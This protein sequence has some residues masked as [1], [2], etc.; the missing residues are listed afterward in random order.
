MDM[1]RPVK[2]DAAA[3][4]RRQYDN[5]RRQAQTSR[6]R[7]R[8]IEAARKL[9]LEH[10]YAATPIEAAAVAADVG[11]AT[12]YRQFGSKRELLKAIIDVS[13]GGDD[14]PIPFHERPPVVAML[15][16]P[17]PA[18]LLQRFARLVVETS[19]RLDPLY[20]VVEAAAAVDADSADLLALMR[21]QRFVGHGRV[22][23]AL[24]DRAALRK[25]MIVSQAHD[26]IFA[27]CSPELRRVLMAQRGWTTRA[28]ERW[29]L[30][31]L[32]AAVLRQS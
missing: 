29:L 15:N 1:G 11:P 28:Y 21:D 3:S 14:Q 10:G 9:F 27:I 23:R 17:D 24:A 18:R 4:V 12:V 5:S 20:E 13:S 32:K 8:I 16:E 19:E 25:G 7:A 6:T 22:A 26:E 30:D 31:T 2:T